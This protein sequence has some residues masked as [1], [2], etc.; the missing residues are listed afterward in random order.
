[1]ETLA[2]AG[3]FS[4][5]SFRLDRRGLFRQDQ[6][7]TFVPVEIG[8]RALDA[9]RFLVER[10]GDVVSSGADT[11]PKDVLNPFAIARIGLNLDLPGTAEAIEVVD[12][13]PAHRGLQCAEDVTDRHSQGLGALAV[14]FQIDLRRRG[15]V[16]RV[17]IG[18]GRVLI[19]GDDEPVR[20]GKSNTPRL[21]GPASELVEEGFD[22]VVP[23]RRRAGEA[24]QVKSGGASAPTQD[25][26][27]AFG[28]ARN[29]A[30]TA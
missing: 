11:H 27:G 21:Q 29:D 12:V 1:M 16:G 2:R 7:G 9:L 28:S 23:G 14:Q 26:S 15:P 30:I 20:H 4:F 24:H 17:D 19:G 3:I 18:E 5:E 6:R 22:R 13:G 25:V 10:P 8:G